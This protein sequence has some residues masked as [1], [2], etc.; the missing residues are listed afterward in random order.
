MV[1]VNKFGK[2]FKYNI[3]KQGRV[4]N[5]STSLV[6]P[7]YNPKGTLSRS[8]ISAL[9]QKVDQE[10]EIILVDD[11][12]DVPIS[13]SISSQLINDPR[14]SI[15][16]YSP[17]GGVSSAMNL[18]CLLSK[19][20]NIVRL[21]SDDELLPTAIQKLTE[22]LDS[23][24]KIV[25]TYGDG[26]W[27]GPLPKEPLNWMKNS[28]VNLNSDSYVN[29]WIKKDFS[30]N[31]LLEDMFIGHPRAYKRKAFLEVGGFDEELNVAEDWDFALKLSEIGEIE[32]VPEFLHK[33]FL[34]ET[35]LTQTAGD[36]MRKYERNV[37]RNAIKRR[38]MGFNEIPKKVVTR[39][40]L[41]EENY[42]LSKD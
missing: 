22:R 8:I 37:I 7:T 27:I 33:Y 21:D 1:M 42:A 38:G 32:R 28:P 35:G 29:P 26:F 20:R 17:N 15:Y 40:K 41:T 14:I 16:S 11:G 10:Y 9:T 12:S 19:G 3:E 25:Y 39:F 30:K 4:T 34:L 31:A 36:K 24:P 13:N 2:E 23:D 18:A 6:I 5:P